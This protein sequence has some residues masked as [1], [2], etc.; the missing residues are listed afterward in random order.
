MSG[1]LGCPRGYRVELVFVQVQDDT[2]AALP[3]PVPWGGE[4]LQGVTRVTW[5]REVN[6]V[7]E[8]VITVGGTPDRTPCCEQIGKIQPGMYEVRLWRDNEMVWEGPITEDVETTRG[9]PYVIHARDVLSWFEG[10]DGRPNL[11]TLNYTSD[12]PVVI[13][14]DIIRRNLTDTWAV[15]N[16]YPMVLDA[17]HTELVGE[18]VNYQPGLNVEYLLTIL[19]DLTDLGLSYTAF[20]RSIYLTGGTT[21]ATPVMAQLTQEH[22]DSPVSI[23]QAGDELGNVGIGVRPDADDSDLPPDVFIYGNPSS[24]YRP[25]Y[26]VVDVHKWAN[27][28][29]AARVAR[30][31]TS[32]REVPPLVVTMG[33][34]AKLWPHAPIQINEIIPGWTR[35]DFMTAGRG[36]EGICKRLRQPAQFASLNVDWVPGLERVQVAMVP[37][38]TPT[39]IDPGRTEA[40]EDTDG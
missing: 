13:A 12:D 9:E 18:T 25:H 30:Q 1:Q 40:L 6:G 16:D 7:S 35:V 38:G 37:V 8:A 14:E 17:I 33:G 31:A 24:P 26:R 36:T 20:G 10:D 15:P 27:D 29:T 23:T 39:S 34:N 11:Y 3:A 4:M 32:G 28:T 22:I 21:A 2:G 5:G 19:D